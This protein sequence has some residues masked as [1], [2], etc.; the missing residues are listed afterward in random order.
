MRVI[1]VCL[2]SLCLGACAQSAA[3][4]STKHAGSYHG[5]SVAVEPLAPG[6]WIHRSSHQVD[7]F[8]DVEAN[9]LVV[10]S[11]Q[12]ALLID[13]AWTPEQ[14]AEL[15]DWTER[16]VGDVAAV[17][18]THFHE[19]R[20]GGL[21]EVRRREIPAYAH[22]RTVAEAEQRQID[23][24]TDIFGDTFDLSVFGVQG[25]AYHPGA[26]H[27]VDNI[28]V[29]LSR[30]RVLFGGCL[31][32]SRDASS[33]GNIADADLQAWPRSILALQ[34]RYDGVNYVVPGHG[35]A[36]GPELLTH[37][38]ALLGQPAQA[39]FAEP[40]GGNSTNTAPT[41]DLRRRGL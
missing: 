9:G 12:G 22:A 28:S 7:G 8:G 32:K 13:T 41:Q 3:H 25:E 2:L 38:R 19:D 5:A 17:L 26:G 15:L 4:G 16:H 34:E 40:R 27:T 31:I 10:A 18:V 30:P 24:P 20:L 37:T 1:S 14:T 35:A 23:P 36:G 39:R 6:V 33:L 11:K 21:P 29:W